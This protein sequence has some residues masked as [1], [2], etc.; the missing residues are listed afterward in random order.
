M[1]FRLGDD[2]TM[3][4]VVVCE[5]CGEEVRGTYMPD[6][7]PTDTRTDEQAYDDFVAWLLKDAEADHECEE[8]N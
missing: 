7:D 5:E 3:D 6:G 8:A 1:A 2:G 4:T